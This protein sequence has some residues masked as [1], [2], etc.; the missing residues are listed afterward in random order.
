MIEFFLF[1][2]VEHPKRGLKRFLNFFCEG[3]LNF[4]KNRLC[5][6]VQFKN[7]NNRSSLFQSEIRFNSAYKTK[8][9]KCLKKTFN[10]I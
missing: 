7:F 9:E 3:F 4:L 10:K 6:F 2:R 1:H 5:G 8:Q